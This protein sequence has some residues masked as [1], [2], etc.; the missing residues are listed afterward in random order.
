[1]SVSFTFL[2]NLMTSLKSYTINIHRMGVFQPALTAPSFMDR[3]H[4]AYQL[5]QKRITE[6][7]TTLNQYPYMNSILSSSYTEEYK[8]IHYT[9]ADYHDNLYCNGECLK[10]LVDY[11]K[12]LSDCIQ[13]NSLTDEKYTQIFKM[14]NYYYLYHTL[15]PRHIQ[16]L[17]EQL[18][19]YDI[20]YMNVYH[21]NFNF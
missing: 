13:R 3:I 19:Q 18:K 10:V 12:E 9:I 2:D 20:E 1:M 5:G 11:M 6:L 14:Q 7:E 17:D 16:G 15:T 8:A 21:W 4:Y